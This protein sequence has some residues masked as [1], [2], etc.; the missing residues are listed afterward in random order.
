MPRLIFAERFA[1]DLAAV[2]SPKVERTIMTALDNIET[3]PEFGSRLIP[4]SI[5][6]A[7]GEGVRKVVVSPFDLLYTYDEA[8]DIAYIEALIHQRAIR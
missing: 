3:F 2:A 5:R 4:S 8:T 1:N 6:N 7:F